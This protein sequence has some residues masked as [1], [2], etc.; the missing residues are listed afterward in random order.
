MDNWQARAAALAEAVVHPSSRWHTPIAHTPRHLLVPRWWRYLPDE[1]GWT[2]RD[3]PSDPER[4]MNAAYSN[5]TLVT[6]VGDL[7]ADHA[8]DNDHP[9]GLPTSSSTLPGLVVAMYQHAMLTDDSNVLCVTGSGYG[10]ALLTQRL[11]ARQVTSIDIDTYLV[12]TARQRLSD[13]PRQEGHQQADGGPF[14]NVCD[15]TGP[16]P[17]SF[18]RI[19]STVGLPDIPPTWLTALKTGGRLVTNLAGTG[20]VIVA[21]R[22][23]AGG[24]RG[25]VTWERA[26][27]MTTRSGANY[28][29]LPSDRHAWR[30]DGDHI[31]TARYPVIPVAETWEIRSAFALAAPGVRHSYEDTDGVRTAVMVHE[32]GSWARATGRRGEQPTVHQTGPRRLWDIL[33]DIRHDWLS[34]GS[35]PVYG[36]DVTIDPD[37][38]LHLTHG[39]WKATMPPTTAG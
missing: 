8:T 25:Q 6:R 32:D 30:D 20:M 31:G 1:G 24:A 9:T 2:L 22:T 15:I 36:A 39:P 14:L 4:W 7:H 23:P 18:D 26:G 17:G 38:T 10:T 37:G 33:D 5:R 16:L 3:G 28:P 19:V 11:T 29:P 34:D 21:D 13:G 12:D 27:F 35:L